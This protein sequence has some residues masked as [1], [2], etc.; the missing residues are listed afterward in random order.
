MDDVFVVF[1]G[2]GFVGHALLRRLRAAGAAT[3]VVDV[4]APADRLEGV[5]CLRADISEPHGV[6]ALA[7]R[8]PEG[9]VFVNLAA[10]Q[11]HATVPRTARQAWFNAVNLDG[12]THVAEL[13]VR[14]RAAGLVQFSSD[15]VYGTPASVPVTESHLQRPNGEYGRSKKLMEAVVT[16]KAGEEN[17]ALTILRPR[18]ISGPGRLGVFAKLFDLVRRNLPIPLIGAGDNHYQMVSADDC[19]RAAV[20][21]YENGFPRGSFNLGSVPERTVEQL[22]RDLVRHAGSRSPVLRTPA[23]LMRLALAGLAKLGIEPLYREQY[24]LADRS[25]VV[26]TARARD[27]LGWEPSRGDRDML[28]AAYDHWL[29][30]RSDTPAESRAGGAPPGPSSHSGSRI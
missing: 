10:R 9:A 27:A 28:L 1:G 4:Q 16:Q 26:D 17:L 8:L 20:L 30:I 11:Y 5:T 7:D 21:A 22:M 29:H 25:F 13:A 24:L 23:R 18:L 3:I 14:R 2:A 6:A 19:A 12:A 15:M